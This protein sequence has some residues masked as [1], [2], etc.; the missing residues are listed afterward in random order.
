MKDT[1]VLRYQLTND[2]K[3]KAKYADHVRTYFSDTYGK[4]DI[5]HKTADNDGIYEKQI[6][7]LKFAECGVANR[8][9]QR[10]DYV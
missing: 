7:V 5:I 10:S 1:I 8:V 4:C 6:I 2:S 3:D 9:K